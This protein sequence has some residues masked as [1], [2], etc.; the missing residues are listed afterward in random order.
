MKQAMIGCVPTASVE[1]ENVACLLL[2]V[3]VK[4]APVTVPRVVPP[5]Q[6][7]GFAPSLKSNEWALSKVQSWPHVT[8]AVNVTDCPTVDGLRLDDTVVVVLIAAVT[9]GPTKGP[10]PGAPAGLIPSGDA[11]A[12]A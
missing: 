10:P 9:Y 6:L 12:S 4:L 7:L 1:V 2:P 8:V 11:S 3:P 5:L